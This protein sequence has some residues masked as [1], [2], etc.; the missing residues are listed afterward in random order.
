MLKVNKTAPSNTISFPFFKSFIVL[1]AQ[2]NKPL[3]HYCTH[4]CSFLLLAPL[5]LCPPAFPGCRSELT[6]A[7]GETELED[8]NQPHPPGKWEMESE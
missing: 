3:T 5:A 1:I 8:V 7:R 4:T 2:A 6:T